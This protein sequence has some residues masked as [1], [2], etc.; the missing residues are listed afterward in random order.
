MDTAEHTNDDGITNS[1]ARVLPAGTVCMCRT[2]SV[3][4]VTILGRPMATSQGF[5]NWICSDALDNWFLLYLLVASRQHLRSLADGALVKDIYMPTVEALR[6]CIPSIAEQRRLV[7]QVR[8]QL[9]ATTK[10]VEA[11]TAE[12][13]ALGDMPAALLRAALGEG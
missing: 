4:L 2:G 10:L 7:A 3:G 13:Q 5:A 9:A 8:E 6:V 1:S 12:M 11:A